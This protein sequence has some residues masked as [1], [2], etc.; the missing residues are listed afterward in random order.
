MYKIDNFEFIDGV[1]EACKYIE[2]LGYKIIIITNQ[3]GISRGYYSESDFQIITNWMITQFHNNGIN[4][5]DVLHCPHSPKENCACRKP[6][7]GMLLKAKKNHNINM[8]KSWLVGDKETD[9]TAAINS[10]IKQT[11]IVKS[12]HKINEKTSNA[13]FILDSIKDLKDII[14]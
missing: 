8:S 9:I 4:I 11:I 2:S 10:G 6:K 12:G 5:M 7:P 1:F 13:K 14:D 3:S